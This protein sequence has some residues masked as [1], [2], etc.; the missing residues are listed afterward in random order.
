MK[1]LISIV[2]S[3]A[4]M[5]SAASSQAWFGGDLYDGVFKSKSEIKE[6]KEEK[7]RLKVIK[8]RRDARIEKNR[9]DAVVKKAEI[10]AR[11]AKRLE[12][13]AERSNVI[14]SDK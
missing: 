3:A 5:L 7:E 4:L 10:D 2:I 1:P 13:R 11:N 14:G 8:K 12:P 6:E 9:Q